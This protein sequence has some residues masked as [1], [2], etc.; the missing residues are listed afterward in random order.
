VCRQTT[1]SGVGSNAWRMG[2]KQD[3]DA[4]GVSLTSYRRSHLTFKPTWG[5]QSKASQSAISR[6]GRFSGD[7]MAIPSTEGRSKEEAEKHRL[8]IEEKATAVRSSANEFMRFG[9][10]RL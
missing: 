7:A 3:G 1:R 9:L 8:A 6:P 2:E 4:S 5:M 10:G